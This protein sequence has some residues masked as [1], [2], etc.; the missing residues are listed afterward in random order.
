MIAL[1]DSCSALIL[2]RRDAIRSVFAALRHRYDQ[3]GGATSTTFATG[4]VE[5]AR[6]RRRRLRAPR[7]TRSIRPTIEA[8]GRRWRGRAPNPRRHFVVL[9]R[10]VE[11]PT[12]DRW[13]RDRDPC[14]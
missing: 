3:R 14:R 13:R 7:A 4:L 12:G 6:S 1:G 8:V 2:R 11:V 5:G 9:A 10:I